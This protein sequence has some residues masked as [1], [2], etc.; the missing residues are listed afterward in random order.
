MNMTLAV[1]LPSADARHAAALMARALGLEIDPTDLSVGEPIDGAVNRTWPVVHGGRKY[2]L[3]LRREETHFRYEKGVAKSA[4]VAAIH[5][6]KRVGSSDARA[7][8]GLAAASAGRLAPPHAPALVHWSN[9]DD[10]WAL[11]WELSDWCEGTTLARQADAGSIARAGAAIAEIHSVRFEGGYPDLLSLG[12]KPQDFA[13]WLGAGIARELARGRIPPAL[14]RFVENVAAR[15]DRKVA[16]TLAHN[17]LHGLH[18]IDDAANATLWV[19]DWDNA[20]VAPPELDFVKLRY[21]T[22]VDAGTGQLTADPELYG[23][24]RAAYAAAGGPVLDI[25]VSRACEALWLLRVFHFETDR[26]L[27]GKP[28]PRLFPPAETYLAA[29]HDLAKAA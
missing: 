26:K 17:D 28:T 14:A 21:W 4:L 10:L 29:L 19:I 2:A 11:P 18:L 12:G 3:R 16:W 24:L 13:A 8:D 1:A 23:A 5:A 9:G 20:V 6:A 27:A 15:A 7:A 25:A 22:R